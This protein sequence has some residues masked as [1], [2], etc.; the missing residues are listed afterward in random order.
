MRVKV[1]FRSCSRDCYKRFCETFPDVKI[2]YS[3]WVDVIYTF[4]YN[5][6][7]HML[8]TGEKCKMPWGMGDFAVSKKKR[9]AR[10]T[11]KDGHQFI[12]LPIDWP[13][14]RLKGKHVYNFNLHSD[15]WGF[16]WQWFIASARF[17]HAEIWFFKPSRI[18]SRLIK[19]YVTQD[20][21]QQ[22]YLDWG[23]LQV[24]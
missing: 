12:I 24:I 17:K 9:K 14:T 16:K 13:K 18:S 2:S 10:Y 8:E 11:C 7:D 4:N 5:F 20:D 22:K 3:K 21:Y 6:R 15:G 19:H 23:K 1:E